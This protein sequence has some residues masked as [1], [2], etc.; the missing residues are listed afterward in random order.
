MVDWA[1]GVR[2][3]YLEADPEAT[4][5]LVERMRQHNRRHA[6]EDARERLREPYVYD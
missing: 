3:R 6:V 2:D 1:S 5:A 4:E